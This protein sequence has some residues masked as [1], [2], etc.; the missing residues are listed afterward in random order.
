MAHR[1]W[2]T[3][4]ARN[5]REPFLINPHRAGGRR[6]TKKTTARR[7]RTRNKLGRFTRR[8]ARRNDPLM[9]LGLGNPRRRRSRRGKGVHSMKRKRIRR[10]ARR[11]VVVNRPRRRRRSNP[12]RYSR[13]RVSRRRSNPVR[14]RRRRNPASSVSLTH[15]TQWM[16]PVLTAIAGGGS[17]V[18]APRALLG[19]TVTANQAYL[20]QAGVALGGALGLRL[21]KFRG[22][23]QLMWLAGAAV[24][25]T[26][27]LV[28]R[29]L[30]AALGLSY[31]PYQSL[32]ADPYYP[33]R[34][35]G[36]GDMALYPYA[37]G[38]D[39]MFTFPDQ[40]DVGA[41]EAPFSHFLNT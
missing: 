36:T 40:A 16:G 19:P 9:V 3:F 21:L 28:G 15:P 41:P 6:R 34:L 14:F 5:G 27:D 24:M 7:R 25:V 17:A 10:N 12:V 4:P 39:Y 2:N 35:Y 8:R 1:L 32:A 18:I 23:Y 22:V 13:R 26:G 29:R 31:Y 38:G 37:G 33:P 20:V 30:M 11:V